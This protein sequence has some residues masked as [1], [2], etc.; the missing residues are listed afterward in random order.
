MSEPAVLNRIEKVFQ[1]VFG[2]PDLNVSET[3]ARTDF[4]DWDSLH[5]INLMVSIEKEFGIRMNLGDVQDANS[6]R[7]I[8]SIVNQKL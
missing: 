8:L 4:P 7:E 6:V 2:E 1:D 5:H 3:M